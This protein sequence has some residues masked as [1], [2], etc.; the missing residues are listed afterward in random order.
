MKPTLLP[1]FVIRFGTFRLPALALFFALASA[2]GATTAPSAAFVSGD[3]WAV[4]GD[5]TTHTG[6]YHREVELFYLTRHPSAPLDVVNGGLASDTAA[7]ALDRLDWDC[8]AARPTVVSVMF[9]MNDVGH[10]L[11]AANQTTPAV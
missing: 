4:L 2:S 6:S 3:R 8:L 5:S 1:R 9:G 11:Y 10:Q 7:S